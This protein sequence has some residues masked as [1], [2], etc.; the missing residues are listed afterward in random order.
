VIVPFRDGCG[1]AN[2]GIGRWK[3]L[4]EFVPYMENFLTAR[5]V[6]YRIVVVEQVQRGLFNKGFLFN[7]GVRLSA[8]YSD[9]M[10]LHDVDQLPEMATNDYGFPLG[11]KP[12]HLCS[13]PSQYGYRPAYKTMVGGALLM[14]RTQYEAVGGFSNTYWSWG[15][16][17][18]DMYRRIAAVFHSVDQLP[19]SVGR[20]RSL[21]HTRV[22]GLDETHEF[23]VQR[24]EMTYMSRL[25]GEAFRTHVTA[26]GYESINYGVVSHTCQG[27]YNH[28]I[29]DILNPSIFEDTV[30]YVSRDEYMQPC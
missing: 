9:Y 20:Y 10:V 23:K 2:Q 26:N 29:V 14:S 6:D 1:T 17:D 25:K 28:F 19:A 4:K 22:H 30:K 15:Q 8:G 3:N 11:S 24:K 18:D 27:R 5:G 7:A 16:E 12:R 21:G 13:A